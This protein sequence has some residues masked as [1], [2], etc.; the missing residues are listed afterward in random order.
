LSSFI[1]LIKDRESLETVPFMQFPQS[2]DSGFGSRGVWTR[3]HHNNTNDVKN[4]VHVSVSFLSRDR[5]TVEP[6][7]HPFRSVFLFQVGR[8]RADRSM[9][10]GR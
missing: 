10:R 5:I 6:D 2:V 1:V 9:A 4:I 7:G 8:L 3:N